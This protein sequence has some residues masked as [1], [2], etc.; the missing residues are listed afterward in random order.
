MRVLAALAICAGLVG[1]GSEPDPA[2]GAFTAISEG[3]NSSRT[4]PPDLATQQAAILQTVRASKSTAPII[5]V[6][7]PQRNAAASLTSAADNRGTVTWLDATGIAVALRGGA[8]TSTRGLGHDLMAAD[9]S[10]TLSALRGGAQS[11]SRRQRYLDGEGQS[12]DVTLQCTASLGGGEM[13]ETCTAADGLS[14][15]NTYQVRGGAVASSR[16]WIGPEIGYASIVR[17]Q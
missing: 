1:C 15:T 5:M 3:I 9:V 8:V 12:V 6:T 14:V 10:G 4:P 2:L 7:L 16:Q 17:L 13:W 11:Y